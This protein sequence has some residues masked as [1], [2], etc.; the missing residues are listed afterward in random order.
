MIV[1]HLLDRVD[2][3]PRIAFALAKVAVI[4][5]E[6]SKAGG[7]EARGEGVEEEL[8]NACQL[9]RYTSVNLVMNKSVWRGGWKD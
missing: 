8:L 4:V 9:E 2:L 7:L 6:G 1:L 3:E 5:D